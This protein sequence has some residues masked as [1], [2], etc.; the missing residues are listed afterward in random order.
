[1]DKLDYLI[2]AELH[3]DASMSF[4]EIAKNINSIPNKVR[5]R[6]EK[7]RKDGKIFRSVAILDLSAL[8]YQGKAFLMISLADN[9]R[10]AS[11]MEQIMT[12]K[13]VIGV[14]EVAGPCDLVAIAFINDM[15][16]IQTLIEQA[17]KSSD[18]QKVDVYFIDDTYFPITPNFNTLLNQRCQNIAETL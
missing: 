1:M 5:R 12:I 18:V 10:K 15:N 14:S 11:V 6:Y 8:G 2:I 3:K 17:K 13:N 7:L 4:S 9:S 16:S